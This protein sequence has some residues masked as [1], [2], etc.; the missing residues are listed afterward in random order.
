MV[1]FIGGW[2]REEEDWDLLNSLP[3]DEYI[4]PLVGSYKEILF[5]PRQVMKVENQGRQGSCFPA[6]AKV[7]MADGTIKLIENVEIGEEVIT[8]KGRVRQVI[9]TMH[10]QFTGELYKVFVKGWGYLTMTND[11]VVRVKRGD[12]LM[13]VRADELTT[14]DSMIVGK[15]L[16]KKIELLDLSNFVDSKMMENGDKIRASNSRLEID[17]FIPLSEELCWILGLYCAE[18][19]TD[20]SNVGTVCRAILTLH[21]KETEYANKVIKFMEMLGVKSSI[22][23]KKNSKAIN[24]RIN[25]PIIA[26]FLEKVCGKYCN[27]KHVP[28]FIMNGTTSQKRKFLDGYFA[29]DGTYRKL[30]TGRTAKSGNKVK[31]YQISSTTASRVMSQQVST[32]FASLGYNVGRSLSKASSHQ[33]FDSYQTYLYSR[34]ACDFSGVEYKAIR[35]NGVAVKSRTKT[36]EEGLLKRIRSIEKIPVE[37]FTVYDFTV[38]EDHS[39]ICQGLIVHNCQGHSISSAVEFCYYIASSDYQQQLS[40][41]YG[42][43]ESQRLD[44]IRGD[45]GSTISGGVRLAKSTGI[46]EEKYWPYPSSYNPSRPS[47]FDEVL[48][49]A[50]RYKIA[51]S[52]NLKSYDAIRTFLGSGQGGISIGIG[53][54][55]GMNK[56]VV[57]SYSRGGG[58]HAIALLACSERKD[59]NGNPYIWM[60]NSWGE[61]FG[62]KGWSEWSPRAIKQMVEGGGGTAIGVSDMPNVQPRKFTEEEW[63]KKFLEVLT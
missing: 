25:N 48:E 20:K 9:D 59:S 38:D 7:S 52:Y 31:A 11:H 56:A 49:N 37:N 40:R 26:Q 8:H 42:Y 16:E 3:S 14:D 18:G 54:G 61:S 2:L 32:L 6:G 27:K 5:D 24:V 1:E 19:S 63:A 21:E 43:Y 22:E 55:S 17:R 50:N 34:D 47:N 13:W 4:L 30:E 41:A 62:N 46:P 10:R 36:C 12:N 39:F 53:W 29:G 15:T 28:F 60:M 33:N 58:G 51:Q 35:S 45:R 57:E 44:G 23:N